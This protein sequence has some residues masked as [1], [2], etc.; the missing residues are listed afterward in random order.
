[1][2]VRV[3]RSVAEESAEMMRRTHW[4]KEYGL[5]TVTIL[6]ILILMVNRLSYEQQRFRG[7]FGAQRV[8]H[9]LDGRCI[10]DSDHDDI[11]VCEMFD[12]VNRRLGLVK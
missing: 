10:D 3:L 8:V 11:P 9:L 12:L 5:T 4:L 1:M 7:W 6:L 2:A